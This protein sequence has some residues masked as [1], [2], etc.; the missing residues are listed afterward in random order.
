L[1]LRVRSSPAWWEGRGARAATG[2]E[3]LQ[4]L[5]VALAIVG[6]GP[7]EARLKS[8][9]SRR[10]LG[11]NITFVSSMLQERFLRLCDIAR[12]FRLPSLH[13]SMGWNPS[14]MDCRSRSETLK[15]LLLRRQFGRRLSPPGIG[16][17][18]PAPS[19]AMQSKKAQNES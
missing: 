15:V 7:D 13:D 1:R 8:E 19:L 2:G 10:N 16:A 4:Q 6:N 9:T 11:A 12:H 3:Q 14:A 17:P 18:F 5:Q